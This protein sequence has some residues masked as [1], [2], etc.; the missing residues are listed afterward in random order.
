RRRYRAHVADERALDAMARPKA[1]RFCAHPR[2]RAEVEARLKLRWSPQQI[3]RSLKTDYASDPEMWVSH[4]TIY[5]SLFVQGR[6]ALRK[7]LHRCLR[8][9]RAVRRPH[10][11]P[12]TN[13]GKLGNMLMISERPAE[14]AD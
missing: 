2:L 14:D 6:G 4:E 7:E 3:A 1:S 12:P 13:K 5:T 11:H 9:G 10:S 8:S